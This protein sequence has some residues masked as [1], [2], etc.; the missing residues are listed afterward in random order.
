MGSPR[1][2]PGL[3]GFSIAHPASP[4]HRPSLAWCIGKNTFKPENTVLSLRVECASCKGYKLLPLQ[5]V[6]NYHFGQVTL[7]KAEHE[8]LCPTCPFL[9]SH[10]AEPASASKLQASISNVDKLNPKGYANGQLLI[11][12]VLVE[13]E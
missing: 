10:S 8:R 9:V 2:R 7:A 12:K 11:S 5:N 4:R 1:L 6:P 3:P 13:A